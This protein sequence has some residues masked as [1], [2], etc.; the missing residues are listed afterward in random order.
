VREGAGFSTP[1]ESESTLGSGPIASVQFPTLRLEAGATHS[2]YYVRRRR[3]ARARR[4]KRASIAAVVALVVGVIVTATVY[5]GSPSTLA[6]GVQVDGVDVGGLSTAEATRLLQ[7]RSQV[8]LRTPVRFVVAGHAF[9]LTASDIGLRPD[10]TT[11]VAAA[12]DRG[13]GFG[14]LR[15]FRRLKVRVFGD[16]VTATAVYDKTKLNAVLSRIAARVDQP[17]REAAVVLHGLTPAVAPARAGRVLD[18]EAAGRSIVASLLAF[19]RGNKVSLPLK[20]DDP[21]VTGDQLAA[22]LA[23]VRTAVSAPVV[24]T[25]GPTRYRVPRWRLATLLDLPSNG[26]TKARIGGHD[27]DAYFQRLQK[28][29]NTKAH[30][31]QF[32]VTT[33]GITIRPSVDA[34]VLDVP[35]TASAMLAAALRP[36][37]RT[38]P[39]A[40]ATQ[41]P[42]RTTADAKAMGITGIVSSYTTSYGGVPNR[43]HNVEV[44]AHLVDN[45]LIGPG[46]EFS[47]NATTGERNAAKGLLEAPVIING[48]LQNGLGGGTCQVSTT[49]FNAAYEAGLPITARTNHA[50]YISHYP[51]GR[52]ATVNYPDLDLKFVNDTDHWLLLRAFVSSS[53]LTVNLYGTPQHRRVESETAPLRTTGPVPVQIVK[54][55]T[56]PKGK[57]VVEESGSPPLATS[58]T[59]RVYDEKGKLLYENTWSSSY[60][61]EKEIVR[62]GTKKPKP[63]AKPVDPSTYLP[64]ELVP[65]DTTPTDTTGTATTTNEKTTT[66]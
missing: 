47:F 29:V 32:V 2:A 14:P 63:K 49:V 18:R 60:Q 38:A 26:S 19:A 20:V 62:L 64:T 50:L 57:K 5:A 7:Q 34:R 33:S 44:V 45:T 41:P 22:A 30:D 42:K 35:Q 43:I 37:R 24:L 3:Q 4:I 16:D 21:T 10:W 17:H 36:V 23:H 61:G 48:E 53:T 46:K 11:A 1:P 12:R 54:D 25:L 52:D 15:G 27:A 6:R 58:V 55:P 8:A 39:I 51:Q 40:V 66:G 31:A 65:T 9:R 56:L 28:S 59:R 13:D